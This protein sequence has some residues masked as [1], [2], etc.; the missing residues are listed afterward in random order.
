MTEIG[1]EGK[2]KTAAE[3]IREAEKVQGELR[4]ALRSV[5]IVLPSLG[6]EAMAYGDEKPVC[7]I[8][9]G[10]CTVETAGK[11]IAVLDTRQAQAS[12]TTQ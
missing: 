10:R 11:L 4:A 8:D 9:L 6:V 7:L 2:Q 5:G 3:R 12:G 1:T